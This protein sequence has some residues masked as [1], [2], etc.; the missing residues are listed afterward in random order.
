MP[1][2]P[3]AVVSCGPSPSGTVTQAVGVAD[4]SAA[5]LDGA[6]RLVNGTTKAMRANAQSA[7]EDFCHDKRGLTTIGSPPSRRARLGIDG[8]D[9][10]SRGVDEGDRPRFDTPGGVPAEQ[11]GG[12]WVLFA[13]QRRRQPEREPASRKRKRRTPRHRRRCLVGA[14]R[15]VASPERNSAP[16][17]RRATE[18]DQRPDHHLAACHARQPAVATCG[19]PRCRATRWFDRRV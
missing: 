6:A 9:A 4:D 11:L 7:N 19:G 15:R 2:M 13:D 18:S 10:A 8:A 14:P 17:D 12:E 16:A 1:G 5:A 3:V